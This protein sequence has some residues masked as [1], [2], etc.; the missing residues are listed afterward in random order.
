MTTE[1]ILSLFNVVEAK[2]TKHSEPLV[3]VK[4]G[5]IVMP[6]AVWAHPQIKSFFNSQRLNG[7]DLN[8]TFHKSWEKILSSTREELFFEQ[9]LH[10]LSTYGS[11]FE[12]E[13]YIP[14]EELD[15][16]IKSIKFLVVRGESKDQINQRCVDIL[17]SGMALKSE[18]IDQVL[19]VLDNNGYV[20]KSVD[21]IRNKEAKIKVID[22]SG[23]LPSDPVEVLRYAVYRATGDTLLIKNEETFEAIKT[24]PYNPTQLFA[25]CGE[26]RMAEIFNRFKPVFLSFKRRAPKSINKIGKLS[27]V[28]HKPMVENPLNVV[29]S[30]KLTKADEKS[31][32]NATIYAL[33]KAMNA[34]HTRANE[35]Q[36]HFVYRIRNGKSWVVCDEEVANKSI[37][38]KNLDFLTKYVRKNRAVCDQRSVFIPDNIRY[39]LPT[40]EKL[41][42]GNVPTGTKITHDI[43]CAGVY[44]ENEWGARDLDLS[45]MDVAGDK[46][47][48]N[49]R[50]NKKGELTYSGDMTNA[51]NGAVE[52]LRAEGDL[53]GPY[54]ITNNVFNGETDCGYK[55]VVGSGDGVNKNYMMNPN[56]VDLDIRTQSVQRQMVLGLM[57]PEADDKVS[58]VVLNFGAGSA[59]VSGD[60]EVNQYA[61]MA[62]V[63]QW[64]NPLTLND[65]LT[66]MGIRTVPNREDADFDLSIDALNKDTFTKLFK[67]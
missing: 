9:I 31:L 65:M 29:T 63:E 19:M 26:K 34:C 33:F 5:V 10:Y 61:R 15:I 54:L 52:Y 11:N 55:I 1:T 24:S 23:V 58:F 48:W 64:K 30:V 25:K 27:K 7:N 57:M 60:S 8:K 66:I 56:K 18:T 21:T 17:E 45:G 44:W 43:L 16:P 3:D 40:S 53:T 42:V 14:L 50:Y 62:L 2:Q 12:G 49:A 36:T 32:A 51:K 6:N 20:F 39:A 4:N 35:S 38:Q 41:F 28:Y 46:V 13:V 67:V 22:H 59:Q 37:C 47:G